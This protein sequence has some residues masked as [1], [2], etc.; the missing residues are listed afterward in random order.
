MNRNN[1]RTLIVCGHGMVAQRFLEEL[2]ADAGA[3]FQNI[4]VFSGEPQRAYN[5]IQLPAL[6]SGEAD[7]ASLALQPDDWFDARG[8]RVHC[9]EWVNDIDRSARTVTTSTGRTQPYHTLV[10][11]T[12][13]RPASLGIAGEDLHGVSYFRDLGDARRLIEQREHRRRA[14]VVGGGFLGLEAA[15]GMQRLGLS[16][17]VLHR[18]GHLL[19]RQLDRTGGEILAEQ[20]SGRGLDILT[21]SAPIRILGTDD[22]HAVQLADQTLISTDLVVIATGIVPNRELAQA[23]GL[24][25]GRGIRVNRRMQTSDPA[26]YA[27]GECCEV[28]G[29]TFGLVEPGY[30]QA[31]VLADVLRDSK[32]P[33]AFESAVLS[34]RLKIS[35]LPVFSCGLQQ[36]DE[37]TESLTWRDLE[38]ATYGHLMIRDHRLVGAVLLGDTSAGAWYQELIKEQTEVGSFRAQLPFGKPFC[39]AA[40]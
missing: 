26:I 12:G 17:T 22:V 4:V 36:P 34:T 6:L 10:L 39:E 15:D 31:R 3:P 20:L 19:N 14:V 16:V 38:T 30:Q 21:H 8:I 35:G 32:S 13:S 23:A 40:A 29:E 7:E 2:T 11:A 24:A 25:C 37:R 9:A 33:S 1:E 27:L 28:G 5:R 18:S